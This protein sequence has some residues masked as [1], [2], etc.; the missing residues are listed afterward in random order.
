MSIKITNDIFQKRVNDLLGEDYKIIGDYIDKSTP[1]KIIHNKCGREYYIR[2]HGF[3]NK[4]KLSKSC[5]YCKNN[6]NLKYNKEEV[7]KIINYTL[8]VDNEYEV[9]EYTS[10]KKNMTLKHS[11]GLV[12]KMTLINFKKH[13]SGCPNCNSGFIKSKNR[14]SISEIREVMKETNSEFSL[15]SEYRLNRAPNGYVFRHNSCGTEFNA[16]IKQALQKHGLKCP[17]CKKRSFYETKILNILNSYN[18]N[19]EEQKVFTKCKYKRYLRFDFY[20]PEYNICIEY[21]GEYHK[22]A[23]HG[24]KKLEVQKIRDDIK[25]QFCKENDIALIRI[26]YED[27]KNISEILI[28]ALK[29]SN[30]NLK[31]Y[32]EA[33]RLSNTQ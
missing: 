29:S 7:E 15:I 10:N 25:T 24:T 13:P 8:S 22:M 26:S 21:D 30:N 27:N 14:K 33:Q 31:T 5:P 20:L 6:R 19:V 3:N 4:T 18:I 12:F 16:Q 23:Y 32:I 28:D 17:N 9:L 1:I 2:P 11:C